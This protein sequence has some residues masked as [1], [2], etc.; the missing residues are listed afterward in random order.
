ML[1]L[2]PH[3]AVR[4]LLRRGRRPHRFPA[5]AASR[6][7]VIQKGTAA[8]ALLQQ[9]QIWPP[10]GLTCVR[11]YFWARRRPCP[12]QVRAKSWASIR[13]VKLHA[14]QW[15]VSWRSFAGERPFHPRSGRC[16]PVSETQAGMD[17]IRVS[18]ARLSLLAQAV[19]SC[20]N[21][22]QV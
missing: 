16:R 1:R 22:S 2:Q 17:W 21:V 15:R 9:G 19:T 4:P 13:V 7:N 5:L 12:H 18:K 14:V 10:P 11:V 20:S 6:G 8:D 3:T